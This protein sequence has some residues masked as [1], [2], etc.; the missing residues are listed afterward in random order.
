LWQARVV[1]LS[2][3]TITGCRLCMPAMRGA[4]HSGANA[5]S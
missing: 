3:T 1:V 2:T 4:Q 5:V